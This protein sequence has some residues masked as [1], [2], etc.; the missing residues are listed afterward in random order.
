MPSSLGHFQE[1]FR[2]PL[3]K[4]YGIAFLTQQGIIEGIQDQGRYTDPDQ[5]GMGTGLFVKVSCMGKPVQF[6][7]VLGIKFIEI[8]HK[9]QAFQIN[10]SG[11]LLPF[12]LHFLFQ[13]AKKLLLVKSIGSPSKRSRTR[14]QM[15][16]CGIHCRFFQDTGQVLSFLA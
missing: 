13:L 1:N 9:W 4:C 11:I 16:R 15:H 2:T 8:A 7:R 14:W 5:P 12:G 3:G 10:Q 6:G